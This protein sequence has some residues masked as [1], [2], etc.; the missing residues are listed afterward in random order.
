[1]LSTQ[2]AGRW[3][4][5]LSRKKKGR[6]GV[7]GSLLCACLSLHAQTDMHTSTHTH[8]HT[9][10]CAQTHFP[11]F[12]SL[13]FFLSPFSILP[14]LSLFLSLFSSQALPLCVSGSLL[15]SFFHPLLFLL[16]LS[17]TP[18]VLISTPPLSTCL[19]S[20]FLHPQCLQVC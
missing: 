9:H 14:L 5:G 8:M 4:K 15:S 12:L 7:S 17:L 2:L 3:A 13:P 6:G 18:S 20:P 1:M 19:L 11:S 16:A 10:S